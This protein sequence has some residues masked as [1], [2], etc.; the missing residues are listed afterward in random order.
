VEL[1]LIK[2]VEKLGKAGERIDVRDGY[3][4]NFLVPHALAVVATSGNLKAIERRQKA[5]EAKEKTRKEG[6]EKL[7]R[8]LASISVT[9]SK[10]AGTDDKLYGAVTTTDIMKALSYE[11]IKLDKRSIEAPDDIKKLG[12]YSITVR[13]YPEVTGKLKVWVVKE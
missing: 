6:A 2:D 12:V 4:R 8:R 5:E 9:V 1:I 3:G 10:K 11:G 13:L 7:A